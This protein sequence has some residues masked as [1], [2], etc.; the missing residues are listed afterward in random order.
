MSRRVSPLMA[1]WQPGVVCLLLCCACATSRTLGVGDVVG[2]LGAGQTAIGVAAGAVGAITIA[3]PANLDASG[4]SGAAAGPLVEGSVGHALTDWLTVDVHGGSSGV[5][6]GLRLTRRLGGLALDAQPFVGFALRRDADSSQAGSPTTELIW[7]PGIK[8]QLSTVTGG[9]I[10][11][12]YTQ[13]RLLLLG[14]AGATVEHD[15]GLVAGWSFHLKA[16]TLRPE[17]AVMY[18]NE[19][20]LQTVLWFMFAGLALEVSTPR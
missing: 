18:A 17:V 16:V 5:E 8:L 10:A 1:V 2:P 4:V 14:S 7:A 20:Q 13:Q 19:P 12:S 9:F 11:L 15:A 3:S 6:P